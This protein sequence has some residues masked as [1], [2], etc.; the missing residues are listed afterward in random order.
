AE[1]E[2]GNHIKIIAIESNNTIAISIPELNFP[3]HLTGK[4]DRVDEYKGVTR[5]IDYKTGNVQQSHVEIVNWEDITTDYDKYSKSFQVLS[6]A[7]MMLHSNKIKLPVE[8]GIIS[9]KNLGAGFLK[10][11]QKDKSGPHAK[12]DTLITTETLEAFQI[13]LKKLILEICNPTID[14]TE[15]EV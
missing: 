1:L 2:A 6:Y 14:F 10:F 4:V 5:I 11:A 8:A 12:K 9:F 15:K 7:L 13:E 3:V